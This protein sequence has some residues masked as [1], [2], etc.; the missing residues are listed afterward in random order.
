MLTG[1]S[2]KNIVVESIKAGAKDY[3]IKTA[4]RKIL[5]DKINSIVSL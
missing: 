1:D 3:I 4:N 5:L 2:T